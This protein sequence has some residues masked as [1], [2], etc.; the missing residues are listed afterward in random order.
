MFT[1]SHTGSVPNRSW[2]RLCGRLIPVG[3]FCCV[4][5]VLPAFA[6]DVVTK[7]VPTAV[8]EPAV[9]AHPQMSAQ[10]PGLPEAVTAEHFD[11]LRSH[12]PFLRSVGLSDSIVLTGIAR[13]EGDLF[14]TL[15]DTDTRESHLV[16]GEAN[17]DGWQLVDVRG[18]EADLES[19][20]AKIQIAGGEVISIRYEKLPEKLTRGG[21]GG[22]ANGGSSSQGGGSRELSERQLEEARKAARNYRDGFSS[23]GYPDKPPAEVVRKLQKISE[24]QRESINRRMIELRNRGLE[25]EQRRRIYNDMLDRSVQGKR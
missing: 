25:M 22:G 9:K 16:S 10:V 5:V 20:T 8:V 21:P 7:V 13:F 15:F 11:A 17:S 6:G 4:S 12:S 14:A 18:D 19:L 1:I 24:S 2:R 3:L 23:D